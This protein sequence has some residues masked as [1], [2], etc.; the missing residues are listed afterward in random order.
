MQDGC[1]IGLREN[2]NIVFPIAYTMSVPKMYSV[3]TLQK[4][5]TRLHSEPD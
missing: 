3:H 2:G 1:H 5:A 4:V